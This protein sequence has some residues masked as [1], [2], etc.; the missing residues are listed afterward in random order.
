MYFK[1]LD[2]YKENEDENLAEI[3]KCLNNLGIIYYELNG[4]DNIKEEAIKMFKQSKELY[5]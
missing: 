5:A 4:S 3:A 2:I 1:A